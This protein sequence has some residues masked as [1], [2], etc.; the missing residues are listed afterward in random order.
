MLYY[1][2]SETTLIISGRKGEGIMKKIYVGAAYYPEMWEESEVDRDIVRMKE[3]GVNVVRV[4]EFAWGKMEPEEGK[5]DLGWLERAV[6]KLHKAGIDVIMCTPTCT[7]PRWLLDKYPETRTVYADGTRTEVFSRCHPCKS[8]PVMREK[9]RIIVTELAKAFGKHPGVIGWQIDNEIFPYNALCYCPLCR[10][11]FR[12]YLKEK[13]GTPENLNAKW[14]MQR[15]SLEYKSFDD[16]I[17]AAHDRWE[18][19]SLRAEWTR[20]HCRNI[21]SYVS[22]QAEILHKYTSVPVGT[23]MMAT[24]LLSYADMNEQLDVAQF[25]HYEPAAEIA[26]TTFSYDFLRTIKDKPFWVTETQVGWNGSTFADFGYRPAGACYANTWLPIARGGEMIEYWLF[27]AHP[28]GHELAHGALFN[29]SGRAY[30]VTEEVA[31]AAAEF[32]KCRSLLTGS[33]VRSKIAI[34]YSSTSVINSVNAPMLKNYDYRS[35]LI[36]RVHAAFRHYNVDVIETNH[37]LD[38]YDVLFSPFLSTVDEKG[39]KER[40]IEW[41]KA[42]GTWVVGP[43]SD[44][45]TEYSSKYANAPYS[46]LEELAGVYTKYE[47]PI[48]NDIYRAKWAGGEGTFAISTCYSAYELKGAEALAVYENG[49]FAGMPVI[50]QHRVGKGKVILLGTLPEADV[51]RSFAGSAPILPASDNLVLTARSGSGNAIIAVETENK[52]GVLVLDGVYKEMLSGRTLEGSVSVAPY[53]VL[54]LVKE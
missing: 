26:R 37:A 46:F 49:E 30:R 41:V 10:G 29:T 28:N 12:T 48:A 33:E 8:S 40:V 9:N 42:G 18:H 34:H 22:E 6:D 13:Y 36:D 52:S 32:E 27:R 17:P 39:L 3:A 14:G 47:L 20:F 11:R 5:F 19:P 7:P 21:I 53:E 43:M 24:N 31:R 50:T 1:E 15:W 45:M 25:N 38:G 4:A 2:K 54:V 23:D 16:V 44:I 51:L 35:T